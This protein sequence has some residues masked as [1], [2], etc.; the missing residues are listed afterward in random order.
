MEVPTKL[1]N[2]TCDAAIPILSTDP[3]EMKT[4]SGREICTPHYTAVLFTIAKTRK[5]PTRPSTDE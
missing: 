4:G 2:R 3:K 1:K 5:Q